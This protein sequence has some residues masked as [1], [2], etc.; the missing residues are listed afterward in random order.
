[1][2]AYARQEGWPTASYLDPTHPVQKQILQTVAEM[3][4]MP[5]SEIELG[6]D[7]CSAPNF[8]VPLYNAALAYA[9][10]IDPLALP[11]LRAAACETISTAMCTHPEKVSGPGRFDTQLMAATN[12]RILAKGGAEGFQG[13][14]L[15]PG[16]L[17]P[18]KPGVGI[19]VKISDGDANCRVLPS[20][21]LEI[22][23][24]LEVLSLD[25]LDALAD[26]GPRRPVRNWRNLEVGVARPSFQL[27]YS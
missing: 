5:E 17:G 3:C 24:Q 6:I 22:L 14:G 15:R 20:V 9:R 26:F 1:M 10:L 16:V 18:K 2:L 27:A 12:G 25:E 8:A 13:L 23:H 19:A 4:D 7:G 21:V 11:P